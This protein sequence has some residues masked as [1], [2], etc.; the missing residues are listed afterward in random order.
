MNPKLSAVPSER[1]ATLRPAI[2]RG[3]ALLAAVMSKRALSSPSPSRAPLPFET[4]LVS[5]SR[6]RVL[7]ARP[8]LTGVGSVLLW[9][10]RDCRVQDN[11]ALLYA[12]ALAKHLDCGLTVGVAIQDGELHTLRHL[13]FMLG[14]L[15]EVEQQLRE[16]NVPLRVEHGEAALIVCAWATRLNAR[17]IVTD[18]CPLREKQERVSH[19]C[20]SAPCAVLQVDA[21]NVV[22]VWVASDKLEY[23]ARTIRP[24][25]TSRLAEYL[26]DFPPL[27]LD[28]PAANLAGAVPLDW[29]EMLQKVRVRDRTVDAG[30]EQHCQ[31]GHSNGARMVELFIK[32]RLKDYKE[33]RNDPTKDCVSHLSPYFNFGQLSVQSVVLRV[34]RD[35]RYGES[36]A[37]FA[38]EAIVRRELSDNFC[39]YNKNYDN[40]RGIHSWASETLGVHAADERQYVYTLSQLENAQ[41]HDDL[42]NA[43]QR[44][45]VRT[46]RMHGFLRMYWAKKVLEWTAGPEEALAA[47]IELNDKYALDGSDPNGYVGIMWSVC[48]VHDQGWAERPVFGKIRYM[49]YEG[50]K[51]KFDVKAFVGKF[52][53]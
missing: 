6:M 40:L 9:L 39:Y 41:T 44:Q 22:P 35:G 52:S 30:A 21:H 31:P 1:R 3:A 23:A 29:D 37:S 20:A 48:G 26:V 7:N 10:Q 49:N 36:A 19:V 5:S 2:L 24:R 50:C 18:F 15:V 13:R 42:W 8:L 53:K 28:Y 38:E 12:N 47:A 45:V 34:R 16:R 43:A 4:P 51:R 11:Y 46:G 33:K 14:G 32:S 25:I 27:V 17:A